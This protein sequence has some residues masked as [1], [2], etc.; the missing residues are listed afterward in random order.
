MRNEY[1]AQSLWH[2]SKLLLLAV[3]ALFAAACS[4]N[5]DPSPDIIDPVIENNVE[6]ITESGTTFTNYHDIEV[7]TVDKDVMFEMSSTVLLPTG[8]AEERTLNCCAIGAFELTE[9]ENAPAIDTLKRVTNVTMV[10]KGHIT[11]HT[12]DLV[13]KYKDLIQTA[14]DP[15]RPYKY[16]RVLVMYAGKNST[17]INEG[18]IDVYF[19]HDPDNTSTIYT[20]GLMAADGSSIINNGTIN[21]YG[22]GSFG[23]RMR[24]IATFGD[25]ITA[26]NGGEITADVEIA[27]DSRLITTGGNYSNVINDGI[28]KMRLPGKI[29]C[30]TRYGDSN[31]I[32]NNTI[33]I[34]SVDYPENYHNTFDAEDNVVCAMY[35]PFN[36]V[37]AP[38]VNR[39]TITVNNESAEPSKKVFGML[40]EILSGSKIIRDV[41]PVNDGIIKVNDKT[42]KIQ[43]ASEAGFIL[44]KR[45]AAAGATM[46]IR[47][48]R[49][50]TAL[51]DFATQKDLFTVI[52]AMADMSGMKLTLYKDERTQANVSYDVSAEALFRNAAPSDDKTFIYRTTNYENM[53]IAWAE[54]KGLTWDKD[55]KTATFS[56]QN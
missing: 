52:G 12:K 43:A 10:N 23:T 49:W 18:T 20:M 30:T 22:R 2:T 29:Y 51:R 55:A 11:V 3:M 15:N 39:G 33:E 44:R 25:N 8:K 45:A 56:P 14:D 27:D 36:S 9:G 46:V 42:G 16:L 35:D 7:G 47:I 41:T 19:D 48:P 34:T 28:M 4:D 54:G 50:K 38:M 5:D 13:E 37:V 6:I 24:G 26:I 17:I 1:R 40:A 21:F 31:I 32:N 53:N